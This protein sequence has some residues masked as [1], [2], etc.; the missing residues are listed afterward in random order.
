MVPVCLNGSMGK[1][2]ACG[3]YFGSKVNGTTCRQGSCMQGEVQVC[4]NAQA[5]CP[6]GQTCQPFKTKSIEMGGCT[7]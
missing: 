6:M 3:T 5:T 4:D 2:P 1:D 7:N